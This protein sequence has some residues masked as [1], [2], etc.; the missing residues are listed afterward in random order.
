MG[1]RAFTPTRV[2]IQEPLK[3]RGPCLPPPFEGHLTCWYSN[4]ALFRESAA[5]V[6]G[7][8]PL[9]VLDP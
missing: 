2:C 3:S 1:G 8:S 9:N 4:P 5:E 7:V 6:L